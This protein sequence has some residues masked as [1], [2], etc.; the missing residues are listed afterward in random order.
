M[1]MA[2]VIRR[3]AQPPAQGFS[4]ADLEKQGEALLARTRAQAQQLL[5]SARAEAEKFSA[6]QQREAYE[7]GLAEG[8]AAGAEQIRKE[9]HAQALKEAR[10][11][12]DQLLQ[13]LTQALLEFDERKRALLAA[14]ETDLIALAL[15][16]AAR[17]C[18]LSAE[19]STDVARANARQVLDMVR[20]TRD[21]V[22][23]FAPQ[24]VK[25]LQATAA[26]TLERWTS[27]R[28]VRLVEDPQL[29]RGGCRLLMH[30]GEVDAA[31]ETQLGR[32]A[33]ALLPI[34]SGAPASTTL[35]ENEH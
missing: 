21:A 12:I 22:L 29:S 30:E 33:A 4:F 6:E 15:A 5:K 20:Q 24:D 34:E 3:G 16:I 11:E 7:R 17:V 27:L 9:T 8:R 13:A 19:A 10:A 18:K 32:V 26:P 14:A 23:Q 35:T 28:H 2:G 25:L 1:R 31:L